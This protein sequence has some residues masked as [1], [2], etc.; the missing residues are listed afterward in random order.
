MNA[1]IK[2]RWVKACSTHHLVPLLQ[3]L[4][5]PFVIAMG[6]HGWAAVRQALEL[7]QT[8]ERIK[9]AAGN[10]WITAGKQQIFAVGHCSGLV[11][12]NRSWPQQVADWKKIGSVLTQ[13]P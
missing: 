5:P 9:E 1:Q 11:L 13:Q 2:D 6:K 12:V 4:R 7:N 10:T 8:P 3:Q